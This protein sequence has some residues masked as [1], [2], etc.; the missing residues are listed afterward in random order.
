MTKARVAILGASGYTGQEL[1]GLV[2][3]HPEIELA[4]LMTARKHVVPDEPALQA[5]IADM[6]ESDTVIGAV[7]HGPAA[8]YSP[9][10]T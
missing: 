4:A 7:C 6:A 3:R 2:E 8:L 9:A 1:A 5:L 10:S